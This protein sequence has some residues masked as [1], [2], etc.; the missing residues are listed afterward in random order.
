LSNELE[1]PQPH[2]PQAI[3]LEGIQSPSPSVPFEE[4]DALPQT[5][6]EVHHHI[7]NSTRQKENIYKWV[8]YHERK[9]DQAVRV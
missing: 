7:S 2:P 8:D 5:M 6:P 3:N 4:S 9:G 1:T